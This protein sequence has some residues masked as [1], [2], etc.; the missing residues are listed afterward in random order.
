MKGV[1][2]LLVLFMCGIVAGSAYSEVETSFVIVER[3]SDDLGFWG[4]YGDFLLACIIV[5]IAIVLYF[6]FVNDKLSKKERKKKG[7]RGRKGE[8]KN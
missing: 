6:N 7:K 1:S 4:V 5:L 3:G 8:G 2:V